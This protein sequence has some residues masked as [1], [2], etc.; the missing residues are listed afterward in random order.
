MK[1]RLRARARKGL[2]DVNSHIVVS[3]T[4]LTEFNGFNGFNRFDS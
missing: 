2:P 4:D 3:L 1:P